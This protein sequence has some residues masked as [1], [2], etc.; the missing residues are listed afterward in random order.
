MKTE[1]HRSN[2][3]KCVPHA[4]LNNLCVGILIQLNEREIM[5]RLIIINHTTHEVFFE[6]VTDEMLEPYNGEEQAYID[7]NYTTED[8]ISWDYVKGVYKVVGNGDSI[9]FIDLEDYLDNCEE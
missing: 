7:A 4:Y 8:G 9:D 5:E 6:D 1:T 3:R 2:I